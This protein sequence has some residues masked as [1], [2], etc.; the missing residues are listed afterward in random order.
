MTST[1]AL[2]LA[3]ALAAA[4]LVGLADALYFVAVTYRW[5]APDA[6]WVPRACRMDE[7]TCARIVDTRYGRALG[8]PNAVFG[9]VWYLAAL[10]TGAWLAVHGALPS[11]GP[12]LVVAAGVVLF[13]VYLLWALVQ[14]LAVDCPLCYLAHGLN[15]VILLLFGAA[16]ALH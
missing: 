5:I 15:L 3:G 2:V 13:S 14:Q 1:V 7:A 8:L 11:C 12:L 16:C 6:A 10:A 4:A 9:A